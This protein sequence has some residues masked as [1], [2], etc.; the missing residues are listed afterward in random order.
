MAAAA[1]ARRSMLRGISCGRQ[2]VPSAVFPLQL[3]TGVTMALQTHV[4]TMRDIVKEFSSSYSSTPPKMK[5]LDG[6]AATALLTAVLQV[7]GTLAFRERG[8]Q[9][10]ADG[11]RQPPPRPETLLAR[12]CAYSGVM[13]SPRWPAQ[14]HPGTLAAAVAA[15]RS[16]SPAAIPSLPQFIYASLVGTFPFNAFLAAFFCCIGTFVL[17]LGL[18]MKLS[19]GGSG[20]S[21]SQVGE[22]GGYALAMCTLLLAS[23]N[24]IG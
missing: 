12:H 20:S 1:A 22:F 13:R 19:E 8:E 6:F 3:I 9:G 2:A 23:W 16:C 21:G 15:H 14:R 17:T 11:P 7:R 5:I 18:R 24:Y 4:D 10:V